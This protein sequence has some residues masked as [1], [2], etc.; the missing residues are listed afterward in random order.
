M[1]E[2]LFWIHPYKTQ[3]EA[4]VIK[5]TE[6]GVILDKTLFY[7]RSGNQ[8]NDIGHVILNEEKF[9]IKEVISEGGEIIHELPHK[10]LKK[11]NIGDRI[12]GKIDWENRYGLMKAHT[13]QHIL[14]ALIKNK[15]G[16]DTSRAF[17]EKEEILIQ[18]EKEI[19]KKHLEDVL[20]EFLSICTI[21]NLEINSKVYS[22]I[23][24]QKLGSKLRGRIMD[25]DQIRVIEIE[26]LDFNCCG[27][28]HVKNSTEIGPILIIDFKKNTDIK[29]IL[30]NKAIKRIAQLNTDLLTLSNNLNVSLDKIISNVEKFIEMNHDLL[31]DR[32]QLLAKLLKLK[33]M[34]PDLKFTHINIYLLNL[35]IEYNILKR[36]LTELPQD[37]LFII[38]SEKNKIRIISNSEN[39]KSNEIIDI[40]IEK[41]RG[42]GGGNPKNA[43]CLLKNAPNNIL[44]D[45]Q[46]IIK[47]K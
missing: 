35:E 44:E 13:S 14:S 38:Q 4:K 18:L 46:N 39:V 34:N 7:P 3:F 24:T 22:D 21:E 25:N 5:I 20:N 23:E 27:G 17:I 8:A 15:Y 10:E 47:K 28:T 37:S 12:K 2:K 42:K 9:E 6:S 11:F 31:L 32:E 29:Y 43:Q 30:G 1:T 19:D 36:L 41:Y 16:I 45:I 33:F 26:K 40:L